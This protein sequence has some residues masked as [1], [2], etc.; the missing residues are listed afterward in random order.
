MQIHM[1]KSGSALL[2]IALVE[3][4]R[5]MKLSMNGIEFLARESSR[6]VEDTAPR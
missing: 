6:H 1:L 3:V 2:F 5:R 4:D